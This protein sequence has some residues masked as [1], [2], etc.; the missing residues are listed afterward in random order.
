MGSRLAPFF[1]LFVVIA[2]APGGQEAGHYLGIKEA[3]DMANEREV[4]AVS[5]H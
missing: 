4:R 3:R 2:V 5:R 1:P